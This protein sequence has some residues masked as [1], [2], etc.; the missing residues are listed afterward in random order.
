MS[1]EFYESYDTSNTID[2]NYSGSVFITLVLIEEL[3][4]TGLSEVESLT[5]VLSEFYQDG[6]VQQNWKTSFEFVFGF[7][8]ETFYTALKSYE[9]SYESLIPSATVKLSDI[10]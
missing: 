6:P 7:S 2:S 1:P 5:K 3:K 8:V 10:F 9:A 4:K